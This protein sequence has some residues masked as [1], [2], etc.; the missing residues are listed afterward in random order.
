MEQQVYN[1]TLIIIVT[2]QCNHKCIPCPL[3]QSN[4]FNSFTTVKRAIDLYCNWHLPYQKNIRFFGGEPLLHYSLLKKAFTRLK[5]Y[6]SINIQVSTNAILLDKEKIDFFSHCP[7]L[8]LSLNSYTVNDIKRETIVFALNKIGKVT[9]NF[10]ITPGNVRELFKQ[11]K[12]FLNKG[13]NRFNFLPAYYCLWTEDHLKYLQ[14]QFD[15]L[16]EFLLR[17][18][19][20]DK[21]YIKNLSYK[22]R[23][24]LYNEGF[25]LDCNGD[26]Y[27]NNLFLAKDFL[28][29]KSFLRAGNIYKIE[30]FNQIRKKKIGVSEIIRKVVTPEKIAINHQIDTILNRFLNNLNN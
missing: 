16:G 29:L 24:S 10:L 2:K 15:N 12:V 8:E 28:H 21:I 26:I 14:L 20:I 5:N 22:A 18:N 17:E 9:L 23:V 6:S 30:S 25:V 7:N 3:W 11:F 13:F 1:N 4:E 27:L 19:F